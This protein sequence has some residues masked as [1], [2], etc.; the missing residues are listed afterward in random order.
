MA[1]GMNGER[2]RSIVAPS[3]IP[4]K[5]ARQNGPPGVAF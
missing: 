1:I 3:G 2:R 5:K 4:T